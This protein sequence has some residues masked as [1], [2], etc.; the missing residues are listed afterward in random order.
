[1]TQGF[2]TQ[3]QSNA[4]QQNNWTAPMSW[5]S[6][7]PQSQN[8]SWGQGWKKSYGI[9]PQYPQFQQYYPMFPPQYYPPQPNQTPQFQAQPRNQQL[10]LPSAPFPKESN[11]LPPQ[12]L[13]NPNNK[14]QQV[15]YSMEGQ[16]FQACMIALLGL[17]DVQIRS[18]R[19]FQNKSPKIVIKKSKEDEVLEKY[20]ILD[21]EKTPPKEDIPIHLKDDQIKSAPTVPLVEQPSISLQDPPFPKRQKIDKRI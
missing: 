3:Y 16:N 6:C 4:Q 13:L 2:N 9:N 7:P 14:N 20:I 17:N 10:L 12:P 18:G 19:F 8:P 5:K 15:V 11:Q 1:M 21:Q